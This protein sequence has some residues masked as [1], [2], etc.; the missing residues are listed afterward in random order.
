MLVVASLPQFLQAARQETRVVTGHR[1]LEKRLHLL[2]QGF[3]L[4]RGQ[5]PVPQPLPPKRDLQCLPGPLVGLGQRSGQSL[6]VVGEM[7][8]HQQKQIFG[9]LSRHLPESQRAELPEDDHGYPQRSGAV[10]RRA[11]TPE[12]P[13]LRTASGRQSRENCRNIRC[14]RNSIVSVSPHSAPPAPPRNLCDLLVGNLLAASKKA[15]VGLRFKVQGGSGA[16]LIPATAADIPKRA[17]DEV[18]PW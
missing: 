16:G 18:Y 2:T 11:Q 13:L 7:V 15:C 12:S 9:P 3:V 4:G 6:A 1:A 17:H 14:R 10:C 8:L 5:Q